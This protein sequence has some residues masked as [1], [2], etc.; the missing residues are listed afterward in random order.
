[1]IADGGEGEGDEGG[2][3]GPGADGESWDITQ[4]PHPTSPGAHSADSSIN[5]AIF[6]Q[7]VMFAGL[8][9]RC[10][11]QLETIEAVH[12]IIFGPGAARKDERG[13]AA[14]GD[15]SP[16]HRPSPLFAGIGRSPPLAPH[17]EPSTN[18]SEPANHR[19]GFGGRPS[20]AAS[21]EEESESGMYGHLN[22][23]QL[24]RMADALI[25]SHELAKAF[26]SDQA[27]RTLL[28][29]AGL[30][31]TKPNLVRQETRSLRYALKILFRMYTDPG[32]SDGHQV[33]NRLIRLAQSAFLEQRPGGLMTIDS[34][35]RNALEYYLKLEAES[36]RKDW[37][38]LLHL[39]LHRT[40]QLSPAQVPHLP[41]PA[42]PLINWGC[43]STRWASPSRPW[44]ASSLR[45]RTSGRC[46]AKSAATSTDS[47]PSPTKFCLPDRTSVPVLAGM[48]ATP[49]FGDLAMVVT[50]YKH[51][52]RVIV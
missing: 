27:Q 49:R 20:D 25:E 24:L 45:R 8:R 29:K 6:G 12:A 16:V 26:N 35:C 5:Q 19:R 31:K 33:Q 47:P 37:L 41:P 48:L 1:M 39:V 30:G 28:W 34:V 42:S 52:N 38:Y 4:L 9:M 44:W 2:G 10:V 18:L 40:H 50:R 32:R 11:V 17:A 3:G 21:G 43:S 46:G 7:E 51:C 23:E 15:P 14:D 13:V 22:T 36:H